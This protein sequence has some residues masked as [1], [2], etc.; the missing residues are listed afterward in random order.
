MTTYAV[1]VPQDPA[2]TRFVPDSF[3]RAALIFG[4][5][6]LL[7]HRVWRGLIGYLTVLVLFVWAQRGLHLPAL[8]FSVVT[9]L[10]G[11]YLGIEG[12]A[13][14]RAA[15]E[16]RGFR[17][18]DVIVSPNREH[19]EAVFFARWEDEP[20]APAPAPPRATPGVGAVLGLFPQAGTQR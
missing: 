3:S 15:L 20:E 12:Q 19:A 5:L 4:P 14:R 17:L 18:T 13:L 6:W 10:L 8:G 2:L 11:M 9:A 7:R 16:R 1:L